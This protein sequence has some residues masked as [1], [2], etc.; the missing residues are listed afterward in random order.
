MLKESETVQS[1]AGIL[2]NLNGILKTEKVVDILQAK[3][4]KGHK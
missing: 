1:S 2:R 4:L 3:Q